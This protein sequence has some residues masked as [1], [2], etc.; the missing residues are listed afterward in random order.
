MIL[1]C[2]SILQA[3]LHQNPLLKSPCCLICKASFPLNVQGS[4]WDT[5]QYKNRGWFL[6]GSVLILVPSKAFLTSRKINTLTFRRI[7]EKSYHANKLIWGEY[8]HCSSYFVSE[9]E[10]SKLTDV[11]YVFKPSDI[12]P[13]ITS[14]S[15]GK[16]QEKC[17]CNLSMRFRPYCRIDSKFFL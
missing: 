14:P 4:M 15:V 16:P 6:L 2:G 3:P 12:L 9:T 10:T 1:S 7:P 17:T 11:E 5:T 13:L 8:Y